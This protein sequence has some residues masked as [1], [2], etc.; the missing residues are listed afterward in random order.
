M[1]CSGVDRADLVEASGQATSDSC[2]QHTIDSS[3]IETPIMPQRRGF[4]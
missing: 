3:G 4:G 2:G 1:V